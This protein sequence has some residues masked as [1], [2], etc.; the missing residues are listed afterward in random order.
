MGYK[1]V[2]HH[3]L[4]IEVGVYDFLQDAIPT[5]VIVDAGLQSQLYGGRIFPSTS[6][7]KLHLSFQSGVHVPVLIQPARVEDDVKTGRRV[8]VEVDAGCVHFHG[9]SKMEGAT[10]VLIDVFVQCLAKE[11]PTLA[12][13]SAVGQ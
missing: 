9:P 2:H 4:G 8:E 11:K 3:L 10:P 12:A 13:P 7:R 6:S 5:R 1:L